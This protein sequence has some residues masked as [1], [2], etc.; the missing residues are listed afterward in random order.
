MKEFRLLIIVS[1]AFLTAFGQAKPRLATLA[2]QKVC[3][4]QAKMT[5]HDTWSL[6]S[7][8]ATMTH[9]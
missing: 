7:T 4:E 5:F 8:P 1:L 3:A 9:Q 2:Q 6:G